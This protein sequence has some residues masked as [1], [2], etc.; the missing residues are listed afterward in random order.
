[1]SMSRR[2]CY[3][4]LGF[5]RKL[6]SEKAREGF[7]EEISRV[8][9]FLKDP[10]L[11][12]VRER[13]TVQVLVPKVVTTPAPLSVNDEFG[14]GDAEELLSAQTKR[15]AIQRKAAAASLFAEDYAR[16]FES[17]DLADALKPLGEEQ[18]QSTA[19]VMCR[20]CFVGELQ[21][22]EMSKKMLS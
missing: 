15:A 19:N 21:G 20:I 7:L 10:W 17:G 9:E 12:R 8:E 6:Q 13:S 14:G 18:G 16:R 4:K 3:C 1:M 5:P 22:S 2:I 11:L